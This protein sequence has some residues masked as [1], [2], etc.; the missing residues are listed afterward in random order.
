MGPSSAAQDV[1]Q[2]LY[3]VSAVTCP[4]CRQRKARRA[5]PALGEHICPVCCGT[6]R[7]VEI[8]CPAD[9][10]YLASARDHLPA[11]V[12]RKQEDDLASVV[13][14]MRDLNDRQAQLFFLILTFLVRHSATTSPYAALDPQ[15]LLSAEL[16]SLV[17][18]DVAQAAAAL[19]ATYETAASGLLYEHRPTSLPADRLKNELKALL[20]EAAK[21][22]GS[23][24]EREAALV[25]RRVETA[26]TRQPPLA[27][28]ADTDSPRAFLDLVTRVIRTQA[29]SDHE[30]RPPKETPRLI[31]P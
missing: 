21:G 7:L 16:G 30:T 28:V 23:A 10:P 6:K 12:V 19:A 31:L 22:G 25:L 14:F 17:D 29:E 1:A 20:S 9:C 13:R 15:Q 24:F 26:A 5:C 4:L 2:G 8:A 18:D 11:R 3:N 27:P